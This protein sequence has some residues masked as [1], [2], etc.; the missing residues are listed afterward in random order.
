MA[1][2]TEIKKVAKLMQ[3][4]GFYA[5]QIVESYPSGE[6]WVRGF[7]RCG[8]SR[9]YDS[10]QDAKSDIDA[11]LILRKKIEAERKK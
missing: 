4:S 6:I 10:L 1:K 5:I 2:R 9:S 3:D 7:N 11:L 8:M